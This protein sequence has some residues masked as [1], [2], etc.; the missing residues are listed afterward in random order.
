MLIKLICKIFNLV[1]KGKFTCWHCHSEMIW[2]SDFDFEDYGIEG[3]GIVSTF[4]CSN[5]E[6][7][8]GIEVYSPTV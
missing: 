8:V 7:E 6:C 2:G 3:D 4:S 1:P 5:P